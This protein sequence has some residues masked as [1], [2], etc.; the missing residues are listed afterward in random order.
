MSFSLAS[1]KVRLLLSFIAFVLLSGGIGYTAFWYYQKKEEI[2]KVA[3]KL[4][5]LHLKILQAIQAQQNFLNYDANDT[6]FYQTGNS[7]YLSQHN[8][9]LNEFR[10]GL[11][12]FHESD[13]SKDFFI[14]DNTKGM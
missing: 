3:T 7:E 2:G 12:S 10:V 1:L 5:K 9:L 13:Q 11:Q 14:R 4:D 8:R 6:L